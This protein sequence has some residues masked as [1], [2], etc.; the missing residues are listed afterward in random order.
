MAD[1]SELRR[2]FFSGDIWGGF[3][4]SVAFFEP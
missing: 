4:D 2:G 3:E 1:G